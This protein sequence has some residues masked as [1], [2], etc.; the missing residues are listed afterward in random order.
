MSRKNEILR[1]EKVCK[2][3]GGLHAL[4]DVSISVQQGE[5]VGLIGPN[6]SGKSTL[7]NCITG[8]Y[9][10]T[11]G[12]IYYINMDITGFLPHKIFSLGIARTFQIMRLYWDLMV[13]E[14]LYIPFISIPTSKLNY[15]KIEYVLNLFQLVDKKNEYVRKLSTFEQRKLEIATRLVTPIK[16]L[17]LDEPAAGLSIEEANELVDVLKTIQKQ[18]ITILII[19]H[20]LRIVFDIAQRIIVLNEGRVIAEGTAREV[21]SNKDVIEV[22]LGTNSGDKSVTSE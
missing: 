19:E 5:I 11:K 16:L 18:G 22:Y 4:D 14:H 15:E 8:Y 7:I 13:L 21:A 6:G 12:R 9:K 17:L 1:T 20:T 2:F 3:F 10:P